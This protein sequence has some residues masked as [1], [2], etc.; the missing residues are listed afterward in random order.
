MDNLS[1][2]P[3]QTTICLK[4]TTKH[5]HYVKYKL[6]IEVSVFIVVAEVSDS[7]IHFDTADNNDQNVM[8]Y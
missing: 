2:R 6:E 3:P 5:C 4:V 1:H 8:L 7:Q